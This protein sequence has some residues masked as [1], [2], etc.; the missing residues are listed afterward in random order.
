VQA[1]PSITQQPQ[2]QAAVVGADVTFTVVASGGGLTY[3]WK[4]NG[5]N[6]VGQTNATLTRAN[7][8]HSDAGPYSVLVAN[9]FN[10]T[11]SAI[12]YLV[13]TPPDI[14][15]QPQTRTVNVGS[16][17]SFNVTATGDAPLSYQWR[18]NGANIA[19]GTNATLLVSNAQN[20][21][22]GNYTVVVFNPSG[23]VTSAVATLYFFL[24]ITQQPVSVSVSP[25][26]NVT[27]SVTAI[28][29]G[30]LRYQWRFNLVNLPDK[31]NSSLTLT[32]VQLADNGEYKVVVVDDI[33]GD[34]SQAA[35]LTVLVRPAL[36]IHPVSQTV[37][38]GTPVTMSAS[39]YGTLPLSFRWRKNP[40][41]I[42]LTNII[43]NQTNCLFTLAGAALTDGGAYNV[44]ITNVAGASTP[45]PVTTNANLT[46][47][48]PPADQIVAPG[49]NATFSA[50]VSG[51]S[52]PS[53]LAYQWRFNGT[54]IAGATSTNLTVSN[55]QAAATG[56]YTFV[57]T[58]GYGTPASFSANLA[59]FPPIQLSQPQVLGDGTFRLLLSGLTNRSYFIE[60]S[61]NLL[62]WTN[63]VTLNYSNG[64]LPWVDLTATNVPYRFYRGR[65]AQ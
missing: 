28:G 29:T 1:P 31:T 23:S 47:V 14:T 7:V 52:T 45:T 56:V 48:L 60:S 6:L 36:G 11:P 58:N 59:L 41:G 5:T 65:L 37:A 63:A 3:Q 53:P 54:N 26:T 16:N 17:V 64:L 12:A 2:T 43:L 32:N 19:T 15:V 27:F 33:S 49:S 61:T 13:L 42:T 57:V 55:V 24:Q 30:T 40:G 39:A 9:T 46:V 18:R 21:D 25:G 51:S 38:V 44:A 8:Q 20:S 50:R 4:F 35:T 62:D 10:S 34:I 22:G